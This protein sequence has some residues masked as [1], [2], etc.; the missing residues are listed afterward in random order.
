GNN[1]AGE[2]VVNSGAILQIN[3]A[4][5]VL[6]DATALTVNGNLYFNALAQETVASLAGSGNIQINSSVSGTHALVI[7][8]SGNT[9]YSGTIQTG[10]TGTRQLNL[11][12]QGSGS[13]TISGNIST[14]GPITVSGGLLD[15][16]GANTF[17]GNVVING[18]TLRLAGTGSI[19]SATKATA[20]SLVISGGG[21][22]EGD[23]WTWGAGQS[24]GQ[25][26]YNNGYINVNGGTIRNVAAASTSFN[27]RG[28]T[29]GV[30]GITYDNA[31]AGTVFTIASGTNN[32]TYATNASVTLGGAGGGDFQQTISGTGVSLVKLGAGSWTLSGAATHTGTTTV[33]GGTLVLSGTF[34]S[35]SAIAVNSA[36]TLRLGANDRFGAHTTASSP[37]LTVAAGGKVQSGGFFNTLVNP[38]LN[39]GTIELTGGKDATFGAFGL[40]GTVTVGG[41]QASSILP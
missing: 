9:S 29:V 36:G 8:G 23:R 14:A 17:T 1:Y 21:A 30:G 10:G 41:S 4:A 24:L 34:A 18:G 28:I 3:A 26:N 20:D 12:K 7:A 15:L 13:Q 16:T 33:T 38:V 27:N 11:T 25:L 19:W 31:T 40:K 22:I 32:N 39:G 6:P 5:G 37:A 35:A 2:T